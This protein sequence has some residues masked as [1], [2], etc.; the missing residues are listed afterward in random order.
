[1]SINIREVSRVNVTIHMLYSSTSSDMGRKKKKKRANASAEGRYRSGK[2]VRRK[3]V[4]G[5][6]GAARSSDEERI[7]NFAESAGLGALSVRP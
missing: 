3:T 4:G 7:L 2:S 1:M 5:W 6:A